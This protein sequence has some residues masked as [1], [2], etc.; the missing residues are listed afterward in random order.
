MVGKDAAPRL[1]L[2]TRILNAFV[3]LRGL[4]GKAPA[5]KRLD[6]EPMGLLPTPKRWKRLI[7]P[8]SGEPRDEV[9]AP[10]SLFPRV[11]FG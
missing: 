7:L 4:E 8:G 3:L 1:F 2:L 11:G 9:G 10:P 6:P 5:G